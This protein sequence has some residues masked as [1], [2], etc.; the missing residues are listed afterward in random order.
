MISLKHDLSTHPHPPLVIDETIIPETTS[1]KVLVFKFESLLTWESHITDILGRARQR[2][3]QL[4]H[5]RYL[6]TN[7]TLF[8]LYKSQY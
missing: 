3:G 8:I 6:L 5:C 7:Q 1:I 2:E 4:Y